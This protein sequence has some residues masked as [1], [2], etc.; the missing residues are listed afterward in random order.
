MPEILTESFC[1][2]CGTR[3]TFESSASRA[4]PLRGLKTLSKG[5][6]NFVLSDD[7]S[8]DEAM[9]AARSEAERDVT[10]RQLD[11]FHSTFNF[12]MSCRQYTCANCWNEAEGQCLSCSPLVAREAMPAP[13]P[14]VD[15][16]AQAFDVPVNGTPEAPAFEA[17]TAWP[18]LDLEAEAEEP[19]NDGFEEI[20]L[21]ARLAALDIA[22][23]G[24]TEAEVPVAEPE[25]IAAEAQPEPEPDPS[26]LE[27]EPEPLALEPSPSRSRS[28][29][30]RSRSRPPSRSRS[31][32]SRSP[33]PWRPPS[34]S[35]SPLLRRSR[36]RTS[37]SSP[38]GCR[39]PPIPMRLLP[40][41]RPRPPRM[42]VFP[43]PR[44]RDFPVA[45]PARVARAAP[46]AVGAQLDTPPEHD[47]R[48]PGRPDRWHRRAVGRLE[49][50][51][52]RADG[53]QRRRRSVSRCPRRRS[54]ASTAGSRC[55][56]RPASAGA[57]EPPRPSPEA[58]PSGGGRLALTR[59]GAQLGDPDPG[60]AVQ[61]RLEGERQPGEGHERGGE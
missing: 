56:R 42:A 20:D 6:R 4:K 57:A 45:E 22:T 24:P 29:R 46:V 41:R 38:S 26:R 52:R 51:R 18:A 59:G 30:S 9:A 54:R 13:F 37:S 8:M 5:L 25:P 35:L 2:R 15:V 12:C 44:A 47:P 58:A 33:S 40:R 28:S 16:T 32:S 61:Q 17:P 55:H 53:H 3:Y 1:E 27:P 34:P 10:S 11:A 50:R 60:S 48:P 36:R 31:S 7:S 49:P 14:T 21:G 19:S 23:D 43:L 39:S